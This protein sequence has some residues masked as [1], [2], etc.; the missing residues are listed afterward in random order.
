[1]PLPLYVD[2]RCLQDPNYSFRGIGHHSAGILKFA[3]KF[4]PE[5]TEIIGVIEPDLP[6]LPT[7]YATLVDRIEGGFNPSPQYINGAFLELSPMTHDLATTLRFVASRN[8][9]CASLIY[10][11][12]PLDF[13]T[14][15]YLATPLSK[16]MYQ[17][18]M[19]L[20]GT[21]DLFIPI[22][23]YSNQRLQHYCGVKPW[24]SCV[25]GVAIRQSVGCDISQVKPREQIL[26]LAKQGYFFSVLGDDQR[27]NPKVVLSAHALYNQQAKSPTHFVIL[28]A[29][30]QERI[31]QFHEYYQEH[32]GNSKYLHI[33]SKL[34]DQEIGY[35]NSHSI[36]GISPSF[37]EGFSIPVVESVRCGS[38][39][40]V[41]D[42]DAHRE[43][44]ERPEARFEP[45]DAKTLTKLMAKVATE[46]GFRQELIETQSPMWKRFTEEKVAKRAWNF[47]R[48][49]LL[50]TGVPQVL[51][52]Q[53]QFPRVA[54]LTP[55][56]PERSGVAD[57]TA[58]SLAEISK[59]AKIDVF[60]TSE[61]PR[62]DP[63]VSTF[64]PISSAPYA[65]DEYD[66]IL[67]V[68]GNSHFHIRA[69]QLHRTFGGPCLIHDNRLAELY[70]WWKGIEHF[71]EMAE[72]QT[73]KKY[74][75]EECQQWLS[76]PWR[77]PSLY[78]ED[79]LERATPVIFH[80]KG[81]QR[82]VRK[83][84]NVESEY[85][86]F[87]CYRSFDETKL[88]REHR[89]ATRKKLGLPLDRIVISTFGY[90]GQTKGPEECIWAIERLRSWGIT[91]DLY[92]V[93]SGEEPY[94]AHL[95]HLAKTLKIKEHIHFCRNWISNEEY[96]DYVIASDYGIQL[97]SHGFGGLSGAML[98]CIGSGLPSAVNEDLAEALDSPDYILRVP[99]QF[100]PVLI[101]E[102]LANA[103]RQGL[104]EERLSQKR[105]DYVKAHSFERYA[106]EFVQVLKI[107]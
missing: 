25:S 66:V 41:S 30:P 68:I 37:I 36:C 8:F 31:Q 32:G 19:N 98:D 64:H 72:S 84:Y 24:N 3:R 29:Y 75:L 96:N 56:P 22:S 61:K 1:M 52:H 21:F 60:T 85:L 16:S 44:I 71:R 20:L 35:L 11:F 42:I 46:P 59:Y 6:P 88:T 54:F 74:T 83:M 103:I 40:L 33:L 91:A 95:E 17:T 62:P 76:Q 67:P 39:M 9:L 12:I 86:P 65:M 5:F 78:F 69:L 89:L 93:G 87:C 55:Y 82:Y 49:R 26:A 80:S 79:I 47:I 58:Q 73:G 63:W 48:S 28:G 106:K 13:D 97:R 107:G 53:Y 51:S 100:S 105:T 43:L 92:F 4:V 7:E 34:S 81:I 90:V 77:L 38:P 45:D 14:D 102:Q 10:D 50:V 99:D 23:E 2:I 15:R 18:A 101:A 27:K 94:L 104:H 57:Y 70:A